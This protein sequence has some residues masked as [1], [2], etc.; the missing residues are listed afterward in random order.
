[1][2]SPSHLGFNKPLPM[3]NFGEVF[4]LP[5][6]RRALRSPILEWKDVKRAHYGEPWAVNT[7][8]LD[9]VLD[10]ELGCW[11]TSQVIRRRWPHRTSLETFL[12]LGVRLFPFAFTHDEEVVPNPTLH[13]KQNIAPD[14]NLACFDD[15]YFV[16]AVDGFEWERDVSPGW[17]FVGVHVRWNKWVEEVANEMLKRALGVP[18]SREVPPF[19]A[20]HIRRDDFDSGFC[21]SH[22]E[23]ECYPPLNVFRNRVRQ[24]QEALAE[25]FGPVTKLGNVHDVIVT[26][27]EK[28]AT[29]WGEVRRMGWV[30]IDHGEEKTAQLYGT[31]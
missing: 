18:D 3:I 20:V 11:S 13:S 8:P 14:E 21:R 5:Q 4:D 2:P 25:K 23:A 30:Y 24:V 9:G 28:N 29:W 12:K 7:P 1:V 10:E 26:S 17:R 16:S 6:L 27:D 15:L 31:W 19:I 22:P